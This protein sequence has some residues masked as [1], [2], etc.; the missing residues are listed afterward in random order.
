MYLT[1]ALLVAAGGL[2]WL[3]QPVA[4]EGVAADLTFLTNYAPQLGV[5]G[6]APIPLWSLDV[7][8]HYYIAFSTLFALVLVRMPA[9]HAAMLCLLLALA[10]LVGRL[11]IASGMTDP[12]PIFYWSH[13]RIDSILWGSVLALG[14]NPAVDRFAWRPS[15]VHVGGALAVLL[16]CLVVRDPVFRE[17]LRYTLQG[18][19]LLVIFSFAL[20]DR[21]PVARVLGSWPLRVVALLSYTLYLIHMPALRLAEQ[22]RL[23]AAPLWGLLM[24]FVYAGAMYRI[25][26][27]PLARMR[28]RV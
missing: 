2:G 6:G 11:I 20:Q 22:W 16:L 17:T 12:S 14:S 25:V 13:T 8:E 15:W 23:P 26:E 4:L 9:R 21:G 7:E 1:V 5:S 18:A 28:R 10:V 19:A 3:E 27:R 24:A